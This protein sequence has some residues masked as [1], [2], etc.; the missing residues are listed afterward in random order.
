LPVGPSGIIVRM[1]PSTV[2]LHAGPLRLAL[3][4]DLG[5][6][7][8]GLWHGAT[9]VL[10]SVEPAALATARNSGC[11]P[12][13]PFSNRIGLRRF[14]WQGQEHR[15]A[16]AFDDGPHALHGVA[17]QRPWA[18]V[19]C[20]AT[21]VELLCRH[22]PDADWPFAFDVTQ[23][24]ELSPTGLDA[25]L[26]FTNRADQPQPAGLGWHPNFARRPGV[27]L[28]IDVNQRWDSDAGKLP[29]QPV[30][31]AG[32]HGAVA[33]L[34]LDHC[35]GGWQG[36][37]LI[38]DGVLALRLTASL[39]YLVVYTPQG[40]SHHAVEPVSHVNNAIQMADPAAHGL[41]TLAPGATLEAWMQLD[42]TEV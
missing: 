27:R 41:R 16:A 15:L 5:G 10:R 24:F 8:A 37:A 6:A 4:A 34:D 7:I 33:E 40:A 22:P 13:V 1:N 26:A 42:I 31:Q 20:S 29:T 18:V 11:F 28:D 21:Q 23:R 25:R 39:P 3:R 14:S 32:I 19:S 2:E 35:F 12:L 17:W 38:R 36:A 30:P 9:P